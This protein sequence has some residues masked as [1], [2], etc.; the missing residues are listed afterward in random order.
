[1]RLLAIIT[2]QNFRYLRI[3][4]FFFEFRLFANSKLLYATFNSQAMIR[5][6]EPAFQ[7]ESWLI[8]EPD[9]SFIFPL[10]VVRN[11][12]FNYLLMTH[13]AAEVS[14][15]IFIVQAKFVCLIFKK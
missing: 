14:R 10:N 13:A 6:S 7:W 5:I 4:M 2:I 3:V 9:L 12:V 11:T 1:M 8:H 15:D